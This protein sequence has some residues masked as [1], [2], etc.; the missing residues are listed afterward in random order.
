MHV[1][2]RVVIKELLPVYGIKRHSNSHKRI[3]SLKISFFTLVW[4]PEEV[5]KQK[6]QSVTTS[7]AYSFF[8]KNIF[9]FLVQVK[10]WLIIDSIWLQTL[11]RV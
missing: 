8:Q 9:S 11:G 3:K 6:I 10:R 2:K 1:L 5:A 7:R 4:L